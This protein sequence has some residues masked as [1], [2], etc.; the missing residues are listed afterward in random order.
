MHASVSPTSTSTHATTRIR[1][2]RPC[3]SR[4]VGVHA[5]RTF[6]V[7][8]VSDALEGDLHGRRRGSWLRFDVADA[9]ATWRTRHGDVGASAMDEARLVE[10]LPGIIR[11]ALAEEIAR[12]GGF[13]RHWGTRIVG[14]GGEGR[15]GKFP[16]KKGF[17]G[18]FAGVVASRR[19]RVGSMGGTGRFQCSIARANP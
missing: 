6:G 11:E 9:L 4:T 14:K 18:R 15:F 12:R 16:R 10:F 1:P 5:H 17:G 8:R 2:P 13:S 7:V 19:G 3:R